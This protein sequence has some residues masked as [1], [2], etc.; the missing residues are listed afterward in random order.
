MFKCALLNVQCCVALNNVFVDSLFVG[1][2]DMVIEHNCI[3]GIFSSPRSTTIIPVVPILPRPLEVGEMATLSRSLT[4]ILCAGTTKKR[5]LIILPF[6][7]TIIIVQMTE[8]PYETV[9][10]GVVI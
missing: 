3:A 10:R 8:Q 4:Y 7:F 2:S 9:R 5:T 1:L 6:L